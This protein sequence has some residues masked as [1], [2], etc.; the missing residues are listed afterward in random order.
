MTARLELGGGESEL[1]LSTAELSPTGPCQRERGLV[2]ALWTA[3]MSKGRSAV[4][5]AAYVRDAWEG[6]VGK[7]ARRWHGHL[8]AQSP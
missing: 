6:Y 2:I 3:V 4:Q 1:K 5:A 8:Q 7:D